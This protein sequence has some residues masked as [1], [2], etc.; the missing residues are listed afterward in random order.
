MAYEVSEITTAT[1]LQKTVPELEK[2]TKIN[3]LV[4]F[5]KAGKTGRGIEFGDPYT[6][7]QF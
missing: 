5:I 3:Q 4:N 1:A 7:N 2:L 6:K